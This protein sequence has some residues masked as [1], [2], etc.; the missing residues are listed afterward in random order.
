MFVWLLHN[1]ILAGL[2]AIGVALLCRFRRIGPAL[3]HALWLL[4]L[5]RLLWPPGV[6]NWPV[7]ISP[8]WPAPAA[9]AEEKAVASKT[10]LSSS[11]ESVEIVQTAAVGMTAAPAVAAEQSVP[12]EKS[13]A[14]PW[15]IWAGRAVLGLWLLGALLIAVKQIRGFIR[16]WKLRR[17]G[18]PA[19][20]KLLRWVSELA[21][22]MNLRSPKVRVVPGLASPLVA[23][24]VRPVLLW[25]EQLEEQL[26][27]SG[28]KAVLVHELAHLRRRDHWVR[29]LEVL[30]ECVWWWNP[31]FRLARSRVRQYAELACDAWVLAVLPQARRAYAEALVEVCARVS[32]GRQAVPALGI[33]G[34]GD[35][36][37]RL[38]MIMRETVACKLPRRTLLAIV[39]AALLVLP[40]FTLGQDK[41]KSTIPAADSKQADEAKTGRG[42]ALADFD[43]DGRIELLWLDDLYDLQVQVVQDDQKLSDL[44]ARVRA[45]LKEIQAL[46]G[47]P[48]DQPDTQKQIEMGLGYLKRMQD[49]KDGAQYRSATQRAVQALAQARTAKSLPN[50]VTLLRVT[51][52]LPA[53][54]AAAFAELLKEHAKATPLDTKLDGD[55]LVVT[56][57]PDYQRVI[58]AVVDLLQERQK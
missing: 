32:Q 40:G 28:L 50:E 13:V 23:G 53:G 15:W 29:W 25:P 20:P 5:V 55:K 31:L 2:L 33:D 18:Q 11:V 51:Y 52:L 44:E 1:T 39:A 43:G 14:I 26:G 54:K 4:V 24:L 49:E 57:T 10:P 6:L 16:L 56:T 35:F 45:L 17:I 42:F 27:E 9:V 48:A 21:A 19:S 58:H 22:K 36:Q 46:K 12:A 7:E 3:R 30:A 47:K 34:E 41:P 38:T 37:R 8:R